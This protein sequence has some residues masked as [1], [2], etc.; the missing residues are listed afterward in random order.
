M[1]VVVTVHYRIMEMITM[2]ANTDVLVIRIAAFRGMAGGGAAIVTFPLQLAGRHMCAVSVVGDVGFSLQL[3]DEPLW[4]SHSHV[5]L[6]WQSNFRHMT[7]NEWYSVVIVDMCFN[8]RKAMPC[9][10]PRSTSGPTARLCRRQ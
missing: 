9:C 7:K 6:S 2:I 4:S 10:L 3:R 5:L 1:R 8:A